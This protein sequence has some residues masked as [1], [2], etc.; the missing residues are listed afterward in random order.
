M[1]EID[2]RVEALLDQMNLE[3]KV[4][5]LTSDFPI[6]AGRPGDVKAAHD[7]LALGIGQL[8]R[9][10]IGAVSP[11]PPLFDRIST[12][13]TSRKRSLNLLCPLRERFGFYFDRFD[14][15]AD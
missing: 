8:T 6:L 3:E 10:R 15:H 1:D 12:Y 4:A 7:D 2:A 5:Q 9:P 11:A 13:R 14:V